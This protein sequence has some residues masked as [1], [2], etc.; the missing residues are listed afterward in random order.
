[1][2]GET[3][4]AFMDE[5]MDACVARFGYNCLVQFEDFASHN[6][7]RFLNKYRNKY[8]MFN[9]DIQGTAAVALAGLFTSLRVTGKSLEQNKILFVGAGQAACG[10]ADLMALAISRAAQISFEKACE[11]IFMFDVDGLLVEGRPEEQ[12]DGPKNKV[13]YNIYLFARANQ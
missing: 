1:M 10:I 9:D 6:A 4:D 12:L 8:C 13:A 11:R 2:T 3:Y 5:F 7:Y